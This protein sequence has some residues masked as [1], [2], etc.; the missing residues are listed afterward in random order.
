M[1]TS[2]KPVLF[3]DVDGVVLGFRD[4][5]AT[6]QVYKDGVVPAEGL[7]DF[8]DWAI[9]HMDCRWLTSWAPWG[10]MDRPSKE[11]L[12]RIIGGDINKLDHFDHDHPWGSDKTQAIDPT[13]F[14]GG[15][16]AFWLDDDVCKGEQKDLKR[17]GLE[18]IFVHTNVFKDPLALMKSWEYIQRE[19]SKETS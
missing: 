17:W 1:E 3:L 4:D 11:Q 5:P 19:I 15:K 2:N 16:L 8:L 18:R 6:L 9:E 13:E 10:T 14:F 7:W 12:I